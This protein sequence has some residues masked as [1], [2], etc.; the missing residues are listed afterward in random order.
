MA[1]STNTMRASHHSRVRQCNVA[2]QGRRDAPA[3][4]RLG[5]YG[6]V[7]LGCDRN[8][9]GK[10]E[11]PP[12]ESRVSVWCTTPWQQSPWWTL[13]TH[14]ECN[15]LGRQ[16]RSREAFL[17]PGQP[18]V[19]AG[20]AVR[21]RRGTLATVV[22]PAPGV[23]GAVHGRPLGAGQDNL[24]LQGGH[25]LG[26]LVKLG[27][28]V[29]GQVVLLMADHGLDGGAEPVHVQ[30]RGRARIPERRVWL[31]AVRSGGFLVAV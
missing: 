9:P 19:E 18:G 26:E 10:P 7:I 27:G 21:L 22:Q 1:A 2:S 12:R 17:D 28:L 23:P 13:A 20:E 24:P 15:R 31:P 5:V 11:R 3:A 4:R 29:W 8:Q 6:S 14:R 30:V 16:R 25:V